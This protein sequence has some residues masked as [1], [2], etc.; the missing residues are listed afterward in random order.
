MIPY[1]ILITIIS[2]IVA[3]FI[4]FARYTHLTSFSVSAGGLAQAGI[5]LSSE[6][7]GV[8]CRKYDTLG[9]DQV[10]YSVFLKKFS[11]LGRF[12]AMSGRRS[13]NSDRDSHMVS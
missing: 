10:D 6:D 12:S 5:A 4:L 11:A 9:S 7:L 1:Y 8:L 3:E 2:A 13:Q